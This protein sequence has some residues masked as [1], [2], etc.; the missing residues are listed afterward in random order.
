MQR[1]IDLPQLSFVLDLPAAQEIF[2]ADNTGMIVIELLVKMQV[3]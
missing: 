1:E 3:V 2:K